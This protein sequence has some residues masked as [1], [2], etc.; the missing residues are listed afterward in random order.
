MSLLL[1]VLYLKL[2]RAAMGN[3]PFQSHIEGMRLRFLIKS[4]DRKWGRLFIFDN[5]SVRSVSGADHACDA[6]LVWSDRKAALK[7]MLSDT[8]EAALEAFRAA[9]RGE[10]KVEGNVY[11]IQWFNDG[12]KLI[13]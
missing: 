13:I 3:R 1:F 4:A 8:E 10:M 11:Y 7:V 2:R 5:G 6:A 12:V 9:A